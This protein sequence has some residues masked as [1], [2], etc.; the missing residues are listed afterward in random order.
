ML[1][2]WER[3]EPWVAIGAFLAVLGASTWRRLAM[4]PRLSFD[5]DEGV[6][7][8]ALESMRHGH[9]LFAEVFSSQPPFFLAGMYPLYT[10]LGAGI[11]SA[12]TPVMLGSLASLVAIFVI[13][14]SLAGTWTGLPAL[15][16]S[17]LC[18]PSPALSAP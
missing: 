16:T 13:G 4:L 17:G 5:W 15:G 3:A 12:R 8:Q 14:R 18:P 9:R 1:S 7:W 2:R 6:Y 11:V 10:L